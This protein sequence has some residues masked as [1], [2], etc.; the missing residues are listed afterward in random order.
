MRA[1]AEHYPAW[2]FESNKGYPCPRHRAALAG[3][4][5]SAI[6]RRSWVFMDTQ[7]WSGVRRVVPGGQV[8]LFE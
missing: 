5:P 6:H 4:G 3:F 2:S 8:S 1:A 7:P